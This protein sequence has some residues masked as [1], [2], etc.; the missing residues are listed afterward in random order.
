MSKGLSPSPCTHSPSGL[1]SRII[2]VG[3]TQTLPLTDALLHRLL[4]FPILSFVVTDITDPEP[5]AKKAFFE[6]KITFEEWA[7]RDVFLWKGHSYEDIAQVARSSSLIFPGAHALI[8]LLQARGVIVALVSGGLCVQTNWIA[9]QLG[10]PRDLVRTNVLGT[11]RAPSGKLVLDGTVAVNVAWDAKGRLVQELAES[12]GISME[13]VCHIGDDKNDIPAFRVC[14]ESVAV[15]P[16]NQE[17]RDGA[18][19]FVDHCNDLRELIPLLVPSD[20]SC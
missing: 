4:L 14:G 2:S 19:H 15:N 20:G 17:T 13:C 5:S 16:Q 3:S 1:G 7:R 9:D 10:I 11:C 18:K 12:H 6:G 8:K